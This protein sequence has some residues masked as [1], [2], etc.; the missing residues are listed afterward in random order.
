MNVERTMIS[1]SNDG[2]RIKRNMCKRP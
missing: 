2:I 1:C